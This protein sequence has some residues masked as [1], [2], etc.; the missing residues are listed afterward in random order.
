MARPQAR[1]PL[2]LQF[3]MK[4]FLPDLSSLQQRDTSSMANDDESS[5]SADDDTSLCAWCRQPLG[6]ARRDKIFCSRKCRQSA[7]RIR[8][9]RTTDAVTLT[10]LSFGYADPPYPGTAATYYKDEESFDGEVDHEGLISS[11]TDRYD[12]WALSTG[13]YALREV[14]PMCPPDIR[15][16]AWVKPIGVSSKTYGLHNTWEALIVKAGRKLRPGKRDWLSAMP[17]R[18]GG[19]LMGRKPL[20]FC[21]FLFDALGMLPGDSF[22]DLFPGTGIVL[23]AWQ[24]VCRTAASD[25][26]SEDLRDTSPRPSS[27]TDH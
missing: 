2:K 4:S 5:R 13:A 18:G 9:R 8:R 14:L 25:T 17:A 6:K 21:A 15:V 24:E 11:L 1:K 12:G 19:K 23:R 7:F 16:L 27:A 26:S 10:P 22:D 3:R 20:A